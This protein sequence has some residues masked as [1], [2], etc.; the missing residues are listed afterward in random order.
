MKQPEKNPD[1]FISLEDLLRFEW[2]HSLFPSKLGK[3]RS[4]SILSGRFASRQ[5][6]RGLDFEESRPYTIGDDI[7]NIDW[8]VTAKT[9]TTH[10]KVFTEEKEKPAFIFV[11]Q[12]P[13]MGFGSQQKTKSVTAAQLAAIAA[14]KVLKSGDRVGGMVY[15]GNGYELVT[16]KR[17]RRNILHFFQKIVEANNQIYQ[18][19]DFDFSESLKTIV[20]KLHN[21]VTHDFMVVFISD[22]YRYDPKVLE[23]LCEI[24]EHNDLL[25]LKVQ[26]PMEVELPHQKL[27][28]GDGQK[29]IQIDGRKK[30]LPP[31]LKADFEQNFKQFETELAKY[32]I[33]IYPISTV[34]KVEDQLLEHFN[35]ALRK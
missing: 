22:F 5:R 29:Q 8:K 27:T 12:S 7:R 32:N 33:P 9:G 15:T 4:N 6:G 11:D 13:T 26:D 10:T 14:Y 23:S 21:V 25:L 31:Q 18:P 20:S 16:P 17:D 35:P 30:N 34:G 19:H 2:M 24:A 1:I 28:L 3:Q